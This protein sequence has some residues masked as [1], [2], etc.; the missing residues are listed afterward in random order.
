M[1]TDKAMVTTAAE[2]PMVED[3]PVLTLPQDVGL[4]LGIISSQEEMEKSLFHVF[5]PE[6]DTSNH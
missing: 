5:T 2:L 1:T 4:G 6:Q 3:T